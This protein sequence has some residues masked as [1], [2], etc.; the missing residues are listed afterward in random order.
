MR[1]PLRERVVYLEY[2]AMDDFVYRD[3][4]VPAENLVTTAF[5]ATLQL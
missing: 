3:I 4:S 1:T 2:R 5:I